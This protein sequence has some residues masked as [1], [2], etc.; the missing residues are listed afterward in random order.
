M[1]DVQEMFVQFSDSFHLFRQDATLLFIQLTDTSYCKYMCVIIP[2]KRAEKALKISRHS[3]IINAVVS[4]SFYLLSTTTP[5]EEVAEEV[6]VG[7]QVYTL[8]TFS[9]QGPRRLH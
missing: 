2:E 1:G 7:A 8:S 6:V 5:R 3:L 9:T 4:S